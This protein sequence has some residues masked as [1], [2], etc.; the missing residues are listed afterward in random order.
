MKVVNVLSTLFFIQCI[1]FVT[2]CNKVVDWGKDNFKQANRYEEFLVKR[3]TPYL[4]S[5]MVYDQFSTIADFSA[6]FLTDAA[7]MVY[8]DYYAQRHI[9]SKEKETMM[10]QRLL[11]ENKYHISFYIIGSQSETFYVNNRA[12][13]TGRYHKHHTL[14]GEKDAEWQVALRVKNRQYAPDSIRVVELPIEFQH[15]FG[16]KY[17]QFKSIYLVKFDAL[18]AQDHAILSSSRQT[19]TLELTS[20]RYKSSLIWQD[21]TYN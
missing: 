19:V 7:R 1:F 13:F 5:V 12:L 2:G 8:V 6:I 14:L 16:V 3:M 21:V 9:L 18:D 10:R 4:R 15:F 11:N 20:S 17:S